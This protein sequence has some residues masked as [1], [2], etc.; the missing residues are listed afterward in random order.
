MEIDKWFMLFYDKFDIT[1]S[2]SNKFTVNTTLEDLFNSNSPQLH[3]EEAITEFNKFELYTIPDLDKELYHVILF[4]NYGKENT[5]YT[6][7]GINGELLKKYKDENKVIP[8]IDFL[9]SLCG[10]HFRYTNYN[11]NLNS[12]DD[13]NILNNVN[14][15]I[16]KVMNNNVGSDAI[17]LMIENPKFLNMQL[18]PYQKKSIYWMLEIEKEYKAISYN[19]NDVISFGDIYYDIY[20]QQIISSIDKI[21]LQFKGGSLIDEVG[22]G[23]TIQMITLSLLNPLNNNNSKK[24]NLKNYLKNN[25][26]KLHSKATLIICPNQLCGQWKKEIEDKINKDYNIKVISILTKVHFDKYTYQDILNADFVIISFTFLENKHFLDLWMNEVSQNKSYHKLPSKFSINFNDNTSSKNKSPIYFN[27]DFV[28]KTLDIIF[29]DLTKN[30]KLLDKTNVLLL[31]IFWH[32]VIVD[33]FHEIYT[34]DKYKHII[35]LIPFFNGTYKWSVTGTPFDKKT[36]CLHNMIQFSTTYNDYNQKILL[37][38]NIINYISNNFFR[39]NTKNSILNEYKLPKLKEEIVWLKFT[40][41]ERMLYNAYLVDHNYDKF[42]VLIRQLCCHPKLAEETKKVLTQCNTMEDIEQKMVKHYE[43]AV[44]SAENIVN[45]IK[46]RINIIEQ[47][48]KVYERKRQKRILKSMGYNPILEKSNDKIIDIIPINIDDSLEMEFINN[49]LKDEG[50]DNDNDNDNKLIEQ[51]NKNKN[52]NKNNDTNENIIIINDINQIKIME[53]IKSKWNIG[54]EKLNNMYNILNNWKNKLKDNELGYEGKKNTFNFFNNVMNRIKNTAKINDN[55]NNDLND[56]VE[57]CGI[58]LDE[59]PENDI[60][61]TKCGHLFCF[62]CLKHSLN[63]KKQCPYCRLN[64]KSDEYYL[65]SYEKKKNIINNEFEGK[66]KL[67]NKVGTKLANLIY[68][69]KKNDKHTIIFS[70]WND[71]LVEVGKVLDNHGIKNTF[72]KGNVWQREMAI[73]S[74]NTHDD[75]KVIMLS[76]ESAASGTNLTKASHVI[77]LDPVYGSYE[78]R[79]NTEW[80]AIGRAHRLGQTNEVTVVRFIIKNTV[81]EEIYNLNLEEDKLQKV[82]IDI[83]ETIDDNI[84]IPNNMLNDLMIIDDKTKVETKKINKRKK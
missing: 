36:S 24:S 11:L 10:T 80:Q 82:D 67:I 25:S 58:C 75:I 69:L 53:I 23:K 66:I 45:N 9:I 1:H 29:D 43:L 61:V 3:N 33:E 28:E 59:I 65:I 5:K 15:I 63:N 49:I 55:N 31:L 73:K 83:L 56:D 79:K 35:N 39:R 60:G 17:D 40:M 21:K 54:I 37:D 48:I 6:V 34:V 76:S 42:D 18:F 64:I 51:F 22:L 19:L 84:T 46:L 13:I 70:Q 20:T 2:Y 78:Y 14:N 74:F 77:L 68:Y 16:N 12:N 7:V 57:I 4:L 32:R 47:K 50:E 44:K 62:N 27:N 26:K 52:K 41:T 30:V 71:L 72:C 81:E 38:Q 8:N